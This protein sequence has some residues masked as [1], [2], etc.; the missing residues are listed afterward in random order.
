MALR[1]RLITQSTMRRSHAPSQR[2]KTGLS[3]LRDLWRS[4]GLSI[5]GRPPDFRPMLQLHRLSKETTVDFLTVAIEEFIDN[6]LSR[7]SDQLNET[8]LLQKRF[9][10]VPELAR[11]FG[12]SSKH[13][14]LLL[15][16]DRVRCYRKV[17][18]DGQ[19]EVLIDLSSFARYKEKLASCSSSGDVAHSLGIDV[20]EVSEL[21]WHGCLTPVSGPSIDGLSDWRFCP[22]DPRRLL[23]VVCSKI[24]TEADCH[25][26]WVFGGEVLSLLRRHKIGVGRFIRDML[27]DNLA[28]QSTR[29]AIG[30]LMFAFSKDDIAE[31]ILAKT[32]AKVFA[33]E[34]SSLIF[35][36][37]AHTLNIMM[38]LNNSIYLRGL[39]RQSGVR[40]WNRISASELAD[41]A[42]S[43]FRRAQ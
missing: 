23:E 4:S 37:L 43:V 20:D 15:D 16:S 9:M 7:H 40:D 26:E 18:G 25:G 21:V 8:P 5:V 10:S 38:G 19:A 24:K 28:P 27:E 29:R 36:Q 2:L 3:G 34:N 1:M 32:G 13:I 30:L 31:Y 12:V 22:E 14:A 35:R 11:H 33:K 6:L 42:K 17:R 41:V 39:P